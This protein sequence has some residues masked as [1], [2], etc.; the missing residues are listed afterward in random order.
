[1]R[2]MRTSLFCLI[3]YYNWFCNFEVLY[4][5]IM[6]NELEWFALYYRYHLFVYCRQ[7]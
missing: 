3:Q 7:L 4:D 6:F 1:M 2:A 5:L